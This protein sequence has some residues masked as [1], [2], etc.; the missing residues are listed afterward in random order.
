MVKKIVTSFIVMF[1]CASLAIAAD[2]IKEKE[3]KQDRIQ[4]KDGTCEMIQ[5]G[6]MQKQIMAKDQIQKRDQLRTP[7]RKR[8]GSCEMIQTG[9]MP[10]QI[11]AKQNRNMKG[12]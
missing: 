4:K 1:F 2:Q 10:Y 7:E 11:I 8:D 12:N 6:S 3:Q 5:T 9:S